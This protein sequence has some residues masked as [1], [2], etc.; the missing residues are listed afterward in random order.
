MTT[1]PE[2]PDEIRQV[3]MDLCTVVDVLL[4]RV[5]DLER[6]DRIRTDAESLESYECAAMDTTR[7]V[8]MV[9]TVPW[10]QTAEA[11]KQRRQQDQSARER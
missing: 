4:D 1:E 3:L 2:I 11:R 10:E 6:R 8:L 9:A 5:A 7:D